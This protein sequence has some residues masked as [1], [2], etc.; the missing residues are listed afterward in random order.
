MEKRFVVVFLS[1][2]KT[3]DGASI[4]AFFIGNGDDFAAEKAASNHAKT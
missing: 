2:T 1:A 3:Q 4:P